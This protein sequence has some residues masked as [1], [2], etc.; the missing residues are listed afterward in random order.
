MGFEIVQ[1]KGEKEEES[2]G[3]E[4]ENFKESRQVKLVA[5]FGGEPWIPLWD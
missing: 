2:R 4:R 5:R 1:I 3:E